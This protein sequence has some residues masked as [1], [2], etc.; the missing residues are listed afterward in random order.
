MQPYSQYPGHGYSQANDP[1]WR[2]S[3]VVGS[4]YP[5]VVLPRCV[6]HIVEAGSEIKKQLNRANA[7]RTLLMPQYWAYVLSLPLMVIGVG[8]VAQAGEGDISWRMLVSVYL[9]LSL[10]ALIGVPL[11]YLFFRRR[12]S[13][14]TNAFGEPETHIS[15]QYGHSAM[16][17]RNPLVW[18]TFQY[19]EIR[20]AYLYEH[21]VF[22]RH[23]GG[24]YAVPRCLVPDDLLPLFEPI[25]RRG[26]A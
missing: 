17:I 8:L 5:D 12:G 7:H 11:G 16:E 20:G 1:G 3:A 24:T 22:I 13:D 2:G 21:A 25:R 23:T 18:S 10:P 26:R 4:S 9:Y 19:S 15:I 6:E 14:A